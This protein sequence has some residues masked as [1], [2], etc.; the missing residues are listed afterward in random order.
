MAYHDP[1]TDDPLDLR[2]VVPPTVTAFHDDESVDY[3]T[4]AEH[5]RFV[6]DRGVHGVFP[7]GTNGEFPLLTGGER[8]GVVEAVVDEVGGEVPVIAGVG[9][10]S[11]YETVTHAEHAAAAGADGIVVVTPYYYPIDHEAALTHYRRVAEAVSLP[12]YVYH[13]PSKTGNELSLETLADLAAVDGIAGV[14]DSSKDVPWLA[15]ATDAHPELTFLAGSDSLLFTGLEIGCSGLVS[16]VAN[17]FPE[18]VVD[19]YEA[20]D[21]GDEDRARTLQSR[22]FDVRDAFKTGGAYMSGVKTALRMREFDAG[23]LRSPLR[24]KDDESTAAMR[25]RLTELEVL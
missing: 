22:V 1:G 25:D 13:I 17:V 12:V 6:V 11:T 21:D 4:T 2:G 16:A 20:Y 3:E 7:L 15:Q 8:E 19:V 18:L 24:L 10:P 23:P 14:K 9:A 5:A